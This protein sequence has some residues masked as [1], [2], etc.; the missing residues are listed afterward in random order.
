MNGHDL[1]EAVGD[2]DKEY[3]ESAG[4]NPSKRRNTYKW[5]G[6]AAAMFVLIAG[7]GVLMTNQIKSP[8]PNTEE[9]EIEREK[10]VDIA[11][12]LING[13]LAGE[14]TAA[15]LSD[16][17]MIGNHNA[18]Y[19]K[20]NSV[21]SDELFDNGANMGGA[22]FGEPDQAEWFYVSGHSDLQYAIRH[23]DGEYTLWKFV[24]FNESD[25]QY[26]DVMELVYDVKSASDIES[27]TVTSLNSDNTEEGLKIQEKIGTKKI[28]DSTDIEDLYAV[29]SGLKCSGMDNEDWTRPQAPDVASIDWLK[30]GR[31][32]EIHAGNGVV[33]D[34]LKYTAVS[35]EF[36]EFG[37]IY[38]SALSDEDQ[39]CLKEIIGI[40][41]R[42]P[43]ET[44]QSESGEV[45]QYPNEIDTEMDNTIIGGT[46]APM[47][48][49]TYSEARDYSEEILD[50]QNRISAAMGPG[51]ELYFVT[52]AEI[53]ENPDRLHVIVNTTDEELINTLKSY[54]T[55]GVN[56]E[57]EYSAGTAIEE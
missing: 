12:L 16:G 11:D 39:E 20:V 50:L 26:S 7:A 13:G 3:I 38:Y 57:I 36:Y 31:N 32:I 37:G 5:V 30:A 49:N 27:I 34:S 45:I 44:D 54:N 19:E 2:I 18:I 52:V 24:C 15:M 42:I 8:V 6:V 28:T 10:Y 21:P 14:E 29:L 1:L 17:V 25:Y 33:I 9:G 48:E 22:I 51:H 43:S 41:F 53:L 56:M 4:R 40:D 35:G 46:D 23:Q 47:D 55:D